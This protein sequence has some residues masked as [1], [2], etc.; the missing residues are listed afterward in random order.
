MK[1][2]VLFSSFGGVSGGAS[3][4]VSKVSST[5]AC[6]LSDNKSMVA[7]TVFVKKTVELGA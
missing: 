6:L 7:W 5:E 4:I 2:C 3:H 1:V